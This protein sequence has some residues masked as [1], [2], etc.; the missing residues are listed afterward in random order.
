MMH[1][2]ALELQDQGH[3]IIVLSPKSTLESTYS[4]ETLDGVN[5]LFFKSGKIK[6]VPRFRR[7][8]NETLL[9]YFA[10]RA[11]K[12]YFKKNT[13]EA[14]IYYSPTIFWGALVGKLK[15]LWKSKSYL[16]LR[17]IFP[18]WTVDSGL[19]IKN[20][21]IHIYFKLF[22]ELNYRFADR[23]GV[24]SSANLDYFNSV[25]RN[26]DKFEVLQNWT[27]IKKVHSTSTNFRKQLGLG[28][29]IIFF[30]GGNIGHAQNILALI[31]LAKRMNHIPNHHFL[32]VG[33]GDEVELLLKENLSNLTYLP[34]VD[35][36]TYFDMLQEAEIG[37]FSLHPNHKTH[38]FPGK[39]L[40]YMQLSK[41][42]LGIVN[43]GNDLK[44]LIN[45]NS[46][47]FIF[48]YGEEEQLFEA[49][50]LLAISPQKRK[51]MGRNSFKL[52][53]NQFSTGK[54][55][56]QILSHFN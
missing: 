1:D 56:D 49:A 23:I 26:S 38:N 50:K 33:N 31:S 52:L 8:I 10:W 4:L 7:A 34:S 30:Y 44:D 16:I 35:Q 41:P 37:L 27:S 22:E 53:E 47:G 14:I 18:Q 54:V 20:S 3:Q 29:K 2:L 43:K 40:G 15:R 32:F 5:I 46:A 9:P 36:E 24:M 42:I 11:T 17:D 51:E 39:L 28:D 48:N 55:A 12:K 25:R 6:N 21:P 13:Q 19:M 45:Q